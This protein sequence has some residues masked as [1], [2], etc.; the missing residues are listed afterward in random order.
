MNLLDYQ[1]RNKGSGFDK[2]ATII[3]IMSYEILYNF[4]GF[5]RSA[6]M[7]FFRPILDK[8]VKYKL[9]IGSEMTF[10]SRWSQGTSFFGN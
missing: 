6:G 8:F 1:K 3:D 5:W 4:G 10:R 9:V 2:T 7:N